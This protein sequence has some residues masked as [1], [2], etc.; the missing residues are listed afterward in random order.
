MNIK[1]KFIAYI[2]FIG[3][4]LSVLILSQSAVLADDKD[5][6]NNIIIPGIVI[7]ENVQIK[8]IQRIDNID[9]EKIVTIVIKESLSSQIPKDDSKRCPEW[10][11]KFKEYGLPVQIFSYIAFRESSCNE[12][13]INAKFDKKGNVTWTL[14][15]DG[16]IDRGLVQVNS[17]WKSVVKDIC[18]TNLDGLLNVDCNLKVAKYILENTKGGLGNWGFK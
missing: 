18:G 9:K 6:N 17:C 5:N 10:E 12:K 14:N 4:T 13:A 3:Y 8:N 1:N 15:N 11:S 2:P 7:E 16:S